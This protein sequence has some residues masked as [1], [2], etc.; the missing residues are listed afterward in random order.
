M[1][2]KTENYRITIYLRRLILFNHGIFLFIF[3]SS[4]SFQ[5]NLFISNYHKHYIIIESYLFYFLNVI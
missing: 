5:T 2:I 1:H 4:I 3:N